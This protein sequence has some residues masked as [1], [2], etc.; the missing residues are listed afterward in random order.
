MIALLEDG[1]EAELLGLDGE[2]VELVSPR[3]FA[4]GAPLGLR[5]RDPEGPLELR[6]KSLGSKRRED[7]RFDVRVRLVN[8]RRADR[9]RL[10]RA[11]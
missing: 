1:R 2:I 10:C 7:G 6:A 11:L 8:L 5:A 3:A 9:E 4:P